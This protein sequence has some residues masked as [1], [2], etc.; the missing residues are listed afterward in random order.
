[1]LFRASISYD[2]T[3]TLRPAPPVWLVV[4]AFAAVYI[5]WGSTYLAIRWAL[6]GLPPFFLAG[7]RFVT[8][9]LLVGGWLIMRGVPLP[10]RRQW[11]HAL[12]VGTLMLGCGNGGVSWAEQYVPSGLASLF[13]AFSPMWIVGLEMII[14]DRQ[15]VLGKAP[16]RRVIA[17]IV[18]GTAGLLLLVMGK[19]GDFTGLGQGPMVKTAAI[20]LFCITFTWALGS[21]L[22][23]RID[24]PES[25][26]MAVAAQ[27][28]T[29]GIVLLAVAA[30]RGEFGEVTLSRITWSSGLS[31]AYLIVFG[32][33]IALTAYNWLLA[34]VS[35]SR[36]A[37]YGY[38]NP[39]VA[40]LIGWVL[41][42]ETLTSLTIFATVLIV[43]SV[44]M[45]V[46]PPRKRPAESVEEHV[47]EE[48][49]FNEPK[50]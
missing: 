41:G 25:T 8:A 44:A 3:M 1:M 11:F 40:V 22:M 38:V 5:V 29:G 20:V 50:A 49:V 43:A 7:S 30:G 15:G 37:T 2:D 39:L 26:F 46:T 10:T 18:I 14:P 31:I 34:H 12:I 45:I 17:G 9:G 27:M 42:G 13:S 36:V 47:A 28:F 16:S 32:S 21:M 35:P 6:D 48:M 33:I 19:D 4:V 24:R 23:R